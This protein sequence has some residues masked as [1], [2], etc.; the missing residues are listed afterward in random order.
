MVEFLLHAVGEALHLD[1]GPFGTD[2]DGMGSTQGLGRAELLANF[3]LREGKADAPSLAAK[4]L[5][6][7]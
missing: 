3:F 5:G 2:H 6:D 7:G 1:L 4:L